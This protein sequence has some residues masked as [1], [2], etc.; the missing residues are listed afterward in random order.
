MNFTSLAILIGVIVAV[1]IASVVTVITHYVKCKPNEILIKYG[2][3]GKGGADNV[4]SAKIVHGKGTLVW[5]IIQG[6]ATMSLEPIQMNLPFEGALSAENIRVD[7]PANLTVA[8]DTEEAMMQT[9]AERLLGM[10]RDA[11]EKLVSEVIYGQMRIV[12]AKLTISEMNSDRDKFQDMITENITNELRKYGLKLMNINIINIRDAANII[13]NMGKEAAARTENDALFR[14]AEQEKIGKSK[15]AEQ[16]KDKEIAIAEAE[17]AEKSKV[18]EANKTRDLAIAEAEK[19]RITGVER[20]KA[21]KE[22]NVAKAIAEK[23]TSVAQANADKDTNVAKANADKEA[24]VAEAEA[25][26]DIRQANAD[27]KAQ[28]ATNLAKQEIAQSEA[29][30]KVKQADAKRQAGEADVEAETQVAIKR[31]QREQEVEAAKAKKVEQQLQAE[32]VIPAEMAKKETVIKAEAEAEKQKTEADGYSAATLRKAEADAKAIRMKGEAE[33]AANE[34]KLLA[35][36]RGKKESLLA[37]AAAY[38]KMLEASEEHPEIAI[39]F[40]IVEK[41]NYTDIAKA[42]S[43]AFEKMNLGNINI[44]DSGNGNSAANFMKQMVQTVAPTLGAVNSI[45]L[46]GQS[47]NWLQ[48]AA[49]LLTGAALGAG[50]GG[51]VAG[52]PVVDDQTKKP[53]EPLN[54]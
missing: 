16:N 17:A 36:A 15:I 42:Q 3:V 37:E 39:Q 44:Y 34:A 20:A 32:K 23:E 4:K 47:G 8:I 6:Y 28:V 40:K 14:I 48:N 27:K 2:K 43:A 19:E 25:D 26:R 9:A 22:T 50:M 46:P 24:K 52:Q 12:I 54:D 33:A 38:Q 30:L 51:T 18:A 31:Q 13:V 53:E 35:D 49:G 41:I 29:D 5:P 21:E 10:D 7:V 11:I 1:L 45:P